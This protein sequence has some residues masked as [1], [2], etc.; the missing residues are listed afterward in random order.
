MPIRALM[1]CFAILLIALLK[2]TEGSAASTEFQNTIKNPAK[3]FA[4]PQ[5]IRNVQLSPNAQHLLSIRSSTNDSH[6]LI[7]QTT[8]K[9]QNDLNDW[10][11]TT[12]SAPTRISIP[13]G[14]VIWARW[15]DSGKVLAKIRFAQKVK[16][17]RHFFHRIISVKADGTNL[18]VLTRRRSGEL[19]IRS[20]DDELASLLP[21]DANHLLIQS[22]RSF[23]SIHPTVYKVNLS[24]GRHQTSQSS[25]PPISHWIADRNGEPRLGLAYQNRTQLLYYRNTANA[26]LNS[27]AIDRSKPGPLFSPLAFSEQTSD[28]YVLSTHESD[29]ATLYLYDLE[30]Q[31][32]KQK[33][34]G[35]PDFDISG[36]IISL[37]TGRLA[38][39]KYTDDLPTRVF[40]DENRIQL[41][42]KVR[43]LFSAPLVR[44][45]STDETN[46]FAI[47]FTRGQWD[48][49]D[50]HLVDL[51]NNTK[52][53]IGNAIKDLDYA[54]LSPVTPIQYQSRD[55]LTIHGYLTNHNKQQ[56]KP[57]VIM[58]HGGP[59]L[60]DEL[61]YNPFAQFV[62]AQG[63]TVLQLNFRGSTGYGR[64]FLRAGFKQWGLNI[65]QDIEDGLDWAVKNRIADPNRICVVGGSFGGYAA[66]MAAKQ[67]P[68]KLKCVASLNGISDLFQMLR[69]RQSRLAF[70]MDRLTVGDPVTDRNRLRQTSPLFVVDQISVPVFLA[71]GED[72]DIVPASHSTKMAKALRRASKPVKL[73]IIPDA[74]HDL[75]LPSD[76]ER[77]LTEL[78]RFLNQHLDASVNG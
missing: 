41:E 59:N 42:E 13:G 77:Y 8:L 34:Y 78:G 7:Q 56:P 64:Q 4:A 15:Y 11:S 23:E 43:K 51:K 17:K 36:A 73:L 72:D 1:G 49:G 63:Y 3:T 39:I 45:E 71:H 76:R 19:S 44:L 65:Q 21:N 70:E 26:H 48:P 62:A 14:A 31:R 12:V 27:I 52:T 18:N 16:G 2:V 60:R 54:A 47:V 9:S 69:D 66:L 38:G 55:G 5:S 20:G 6:I 28:I 50:Y 25:T 75:S 29:K 40:L 68:N 61:E 46:R 67:M 30:N 24:T 33:I 74:D 58:P 10:L 32:F 22:T 35:H 37:T 53:P 57:L